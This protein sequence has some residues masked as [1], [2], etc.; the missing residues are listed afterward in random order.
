MRAPAS[1]ACRALAPHPL[2]RRGQRLAAAV[3]AV[4]AVDQLAL[5]AG[6]V[7]VGVDVPDLGQLVVV[8]APGAAATI[9]RQDAGAGREQVLL[10]ADARPTAR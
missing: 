6:H 7:A 1:I 5:E 2:E 9:C 4:A 8:D 10:G 3:H